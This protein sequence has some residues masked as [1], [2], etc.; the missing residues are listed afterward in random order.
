MAEQQLRWHAVVED[1]L[2]NQARLN[3][4]HKEYEILQGH[5]LGN[6]DETC[7]TVNADGSMRVKK[8]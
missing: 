2:N 7:L 3:Y 8:D 5:F 6:L 4:P 1:A